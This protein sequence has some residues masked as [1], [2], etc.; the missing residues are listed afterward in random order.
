MKKRISGALL[1]LLL[2]AIPFSA[3]GS[4][5]QTSAGVIIEEAQQIDEEQATVIEESVQEQLTEAFGPDIVKMM[6]EKDP[7]DTP[8]GASD[9][10]ITEEQ[11]DPQDAVMSFARSRLDEVYVKGAGTYGRSSLTS[12]Q[13]RFYDLLDQQVTLFVISGKDA[14]KSKSTYYAN[15]GISFLDCGISREEALHAYVA[16]HNDHPMYYWFLG[17]S[18]TYSTFFVRVREEY[19]S[20]AVRDQIDRQIISGVKKFADKAS[21]GKNDFEKIVIVG[22]ELME[23]VDY[24]YE[25]DGETPVGEKWAHSPIGVFDETYGRM[26]CEGYADTVSLV[27]NYLGIPN[28]YIIGDTKEDEEDPG[29]HAWNAVSYDQG[30][31]YSY[32]DFTWDD[33]GHDEVGNTNP[34]LFMYFGMP[35]SEFEKNH[36]PYTPNKSGLNWQYPLPSGLTDDMAHTYFMY[37]QFYLDTAAGDAVS[38]Y[39]QMY[40]SM[41]EGTR[42]F[43]MMTNDYSVRQSLS[44]YGK[45]YN[46][47]LKGQDYYVLRTLSRSTRYVTPLSDFS[48]ETSQKKITNKDDALEIAI[49][50]VSSSDPQAAADEMLFVTSSDPQVLTVDNPHVLAANGQKIRAIVRET[51]TATLT[52]RSSESGIVRSCDVTVEN[53]IPI[54]G[55][56]LSRSNA[57]LGVGAETLQLTAAVLPANASQR[58]VW[59]SSDTKVAT[60]DE[61]GLV[62][63][64]GKGDC[65]IYAAS[66]HAAGKSAQ[67][68]VRVLTNGTKI[69]FHLFKDGHAW[70]DETRPVITVK[71]KVDGKIYTEGDFMPAGSGESYRGSEM[72]QSA[73][74][75]PDAPKSLGYY[76]NLSFYTVRFL[77]EDGTVLDTQCVYSGT[78]PVY[79]GP[80]LTKKG[81][82]AALYS[83][84]WSP[85]LG[86]VRSKTD[87]KAVYKL[88]DNKVRE[89]AKKE[90]KKQGYSLQSDG[91]SV[92]YNGTG[93][94]NI[95]K[96]KIPASVVVGRK[97]YPV[98]KIGDNA[99]SGCT[100]LTTLV[101]GKNVKIIGKNAFKNCKKLKTVT[102]PAKVYKIGKGAFYGCKK[103]KK[104]VIKSKQ[105]KDKNIGKTAFGKTK[106]KMVFKVPKIKKTIYNGFLKK[107]GNKTAVVKG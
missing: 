44:L 48:L 81:A 47:P 4:E 25:E 19:I 67:C 5:P 22:N 15:E 50:G 12:A 51:G 76:F 82:D 80:A 59:T 33:M 16:Y 56:T 1:V 71:S 24:A 17:P 31:T 20:A 92:T 61:N 46:L 36:M 32:M 49:T 41:P 75:I 43:A 13:Q 83:V 77:D 102:I 10:G 21:R 53:A 35:K 39:E 37:G 60:V 40:A 23:T 96:C 85:S 27:L 90:L 97:A 68:E 84:S 73:I 54:Q 34:A 11:L 64:V 30:V 69:S 18:Y 70:E 87:Y 7:A 6:Q 95:K 52:V 99:F 93:K 103:L 89:A 62:T 100:N 91:K 3:A 107:K 63:P 58:C 65:T 29:L 66:K 98:T 86:K 88:D 8:D 74:T 105:L 26:V 57:S 101:I 28:L 106:R 38:A 45:W 55:V 14:V 104:V 72:L 42:F 9:T 78:V 2:S 94:K 79:K